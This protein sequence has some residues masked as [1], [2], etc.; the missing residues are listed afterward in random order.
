MGKE[1]NITVHLDIN[2]PLQAECTACFM[3]IDM[4]GEEKAFTDLSSG[5]L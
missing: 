2:I 5:V 1:L 4:K 3:K